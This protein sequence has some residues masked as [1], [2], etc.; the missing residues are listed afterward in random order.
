MSRRATRTPQARR[1]IIEIAVLIAADH[2]RAADRFLDAVEDAVSKLTW[3]PGLGAARS[4]SNRRF[5]GCA[6]GRSRASAIS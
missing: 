5:A 1:D 2:P 3:M 6:H 4:F